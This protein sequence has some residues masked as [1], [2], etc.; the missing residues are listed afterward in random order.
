MYL[1]YI[2]N[3]FKPWFWG[4]MDVKLFKY[5]YIVYL[6]REESYLDRQD[7]SMIQ[8]QRVQ[9]AQSL[10]MSVVLRRS[11]STRTTGTGLSHS[12]HPLRSVDFCSGLKNIQQNDPGPTTR[13]TVSSGRCWQAEGSDQ[14]QPDAFHQPGS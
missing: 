12:Q 14:Q 11:P 6:Q 3:C 10:V 13:R 9:R 8:R 2:S 5:I 4:W 1:L 7:K